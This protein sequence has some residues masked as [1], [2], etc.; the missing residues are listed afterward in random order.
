MRKWVYI[1]KNRYSFFFQLWYEYN[2]LNCFFFSNKIPETKK[3]G[4][5]W[6]LLS[7]IKDALIKH[8]LLK[9]MTTINVNTWK[10]K[11]CNIKKKKRDKIRNKVTIINTQFTHFTRSKHSLCRSR[12][13][14][15]TFIKICTSINANSQLWE[16]PRS[17]SHECL[18]IQG[19]P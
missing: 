1:L 13:C 11:Q 14:T 15:F 17:A 3:V 19:V 2:S 9:Q 16:M 6:H 12:T 4:P 7:D 5:T 10:K 8:S 18:G